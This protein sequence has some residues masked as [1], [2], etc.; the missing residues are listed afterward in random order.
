MFLLV[1]PEL[2]DLQKLQTQIPGTRLP[3]ARIAAFCLKAQI[4]GAPVPL[5]WL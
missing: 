2:Q 3:E 4:A 5:F 1:T